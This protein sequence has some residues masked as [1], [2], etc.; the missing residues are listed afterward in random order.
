[1]AT[2]Q[3]LPMVSNQKAYGPVNVVL[4]QPY[5]TTDSGR[6]FGVNVQVKL[7]FMYASATKVS[8]AGELYQYECSRL[9][10]RK[11]TETVCLKGEIS[12]PKQSGSWN[13]KDGVALQP[14]RNAACS[15]KPNQEKLWRVRIRLGPSGGKMVR[16]YDGP[17]N[18]IEVRPPPSGNFTE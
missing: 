6:G 10:G 16:V 13:D 11:R 12:V 8:V 17:I 14:D 1:M 2:R 3:R 5:W 4:Q 7:S 9:M 18:N 15:I